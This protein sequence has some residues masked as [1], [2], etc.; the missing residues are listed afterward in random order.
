MKETIWKPGVTLGIYKP[1]GPTSFDIIRKIKRMSGIKRVGHAGTL[2]PLASGVLVVGI[3]R[4]ATKKLHEIVGQEKE[5]V[6]T[7]K[8]GQTSTTDDE[9]GEKTT[10]TPV[11]IPSPNDVERA[12]QKFIGVVEQTP[13]QFSAVKIMGRPAYKSAR[14]GKNVELKPR[15]VEIKKIEILNYKYPF[16]KL[17]VLTGKGVY[18][19]SLARDIGAALKTGGYVAELER[20]RVGEFDLQNAV[21]FH[22]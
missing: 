2:D 14:R 18:V 11:L 15:R 12:V 8:L 4:E 20:T 17:R 10:I 22:K 5:Y 6:T 21:N 3:G 1:K 13:P 7:I 9:E 19:R 16:L